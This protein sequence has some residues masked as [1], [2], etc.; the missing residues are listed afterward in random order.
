VNKSLLRAPLLAL[1]L[2]VLAF[3]QTGTLPTKV[4]IIHIQNAILQTADGKKAAADLDAKYQP[5]RKDVE[6]KQ[7]ELQQLEQQYRSGANTMSDDAR[8]KLMRDIDMRRKQLQRDMDD[9]QTELQQDQERVLQDLGQKM[10][11]VIDKYASDRGFA[12]ILDVSSPQTPVLYAANAIDITRDIVELYD[13]AQGGAA[14][15]A[16]SAPRP[17]AG[18]P[19]PASAARP[20]AARPTPKK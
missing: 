13:K 12:L 20:P 6:Q 10:M 11:A 18:T 2:G 19:A 9:A 4:G 5:R 16:A 7:S 14:A 1:G 17:A 15:P 8:Q 3:G